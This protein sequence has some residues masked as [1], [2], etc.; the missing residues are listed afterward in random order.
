MRSI[1][2]NSLYLLSRRERTRSYTSRT[3]GRNEGM[4]VTSRHTKH[5][6]HTKYTP[7][8]VLIPSYTCIPYINHQTATTPTKH[9]SPHTMNSVKCKH[10]HVRPSHPLN[11]LSISSRLPSPAQAGAR[12]LYSHRPSAPRPT[13][14]QPTLSPQGEHAA[15]SRAAR[16]PSIN[17]DCLSITHRNSSVND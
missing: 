5:T 8:R 13:S 14:D 17:P 3:N 7:I 1:N 4:K 2:C 15:R 9:P 10:T 11:L 12:V 6:K 16:A